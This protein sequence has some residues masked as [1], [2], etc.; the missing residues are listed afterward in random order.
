MYCSSD[1]DR[2]SPTVPDS[3]SFTLNGEHADQRPNRSCWFDNGKAE[4]TLFV[5]PGFR[6]HFSGEFEI[7]GL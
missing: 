7:R 4:G 2:Y 3:K 1:C 6:M 5:D